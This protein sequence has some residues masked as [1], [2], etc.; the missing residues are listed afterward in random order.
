MY[1]SQE[2]M[3]AQAAKNPID[4]WTERAKAIKWFS[5]PEE[6]QW[7]D[8]EGLIHWYKGGNLNTCYLA[9][10]RHIE[11]GRGDKKAIVYDSPVTG[12]KKQYSFAAAR[13]EVAK[14][15]GVLR[16]YGVEKGDRVVIYMPMVPETVFAMLAC[17]RIGAVHSVVFG[18]FAAQELATRIDDAEPK[19]LLIASGGI[20]VSKII[21]YKP[22]VD[23][24]MELAKHKPANIIV[25]Q[26]DFAVAEMQ[27]GR[28]VDWQ[29][30]MASAQAVDC[31][32]VKAGRSFVYPV[33]IR[34]DWQAERS[35]A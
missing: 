23:E 22:I 9:L 32:P 33:Y 10:D 24:A 5:F 15:A 4:F 27:A 13:D 1:N 2:Q 26:R 7:T 30:A 8:D 28:D 18:G 17:A 11:E 29:E 34:Y 20:E 14:L 6:I 12:Q 3:S 25:L 21:P 35:F 31:V 19:L 16:N